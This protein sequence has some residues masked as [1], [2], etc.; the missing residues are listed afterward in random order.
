[1][2]QHTTIIHEDL[3]ALNLAVAERW[4]LL[5]HEAIKHH[6]SFH[7]ALAGGST[8]QQLYRLLAS[9]AFRKQVPWQQ[10]HVYFGD[11]RCVPADHQDSNYLMAATALFDQVPLP[12]QNIHR[13]RAELDN[14][15]QAAA[16]Y[17]AT[18]I[19]HLPTNTHQQPS[20]DLILLGMGDDGHTAS[21]FPATD[22][23]TEQSKLVAAVY[24]E[25]LQRW[26]ISL[27]LPTLEQAQHRL[28]MVAGSGKAAMIAQVLE[29]AIGETL[30]PVQ[31]IQAPSEWHLDRSAAAKLD[32]SS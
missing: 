21:L 30:L 14:H 8:P 7:V 4:L 31:M 10:T 23:L 19:Q 27:T 1:M 12:A 25:K 22:I 2:T 13:I 15:D 18:L 16:D 20:F 5:A 29:P 17:Q 24:V 26:R 9:D 3:T 11:E 6:L 28:F 32:R